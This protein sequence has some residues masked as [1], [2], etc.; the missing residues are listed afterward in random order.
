MNS[1][2]SLSNEALVITDADLD[3]IDGGIF[4]LPPVVPWIVLKYLLQSL[5]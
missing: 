3:A 4:L 1:I 2:E 5:S